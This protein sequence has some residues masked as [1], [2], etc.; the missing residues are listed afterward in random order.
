MVVPSEGGRGSKK[1]CRVV[2]TDA[3]N[4]KR[5]TKGARKVH[6]MVQRGCVRSKRLC[7]KGLRRLAG[8]AGEKVQNVTKDCVGYIPQPLHLF[9]GRGSE[10]GWRFWLAGQTLN[11]TCGTNGD[12]E[13]EKKPD[14]NPGTGRIR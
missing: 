1:G 13:T 4:F 10:C 3:D 11:A 8:R 12:H 6:Q 5:R 7:G 9:A 2:C 14:S